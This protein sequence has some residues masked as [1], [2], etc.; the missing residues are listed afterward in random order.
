MDG[1]LMLDKVLFVYKDIESGEIYVVIDS[2][3]LYITYLLDFKNNLA[4]WIGASNDDV[5]RNGKLVK[6]GEE[7]LGAG[8]VKKVM[9]TANELNEVLSKEYNF[10]A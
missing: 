9:L 4:I 2:D 5:I 3:G 8:D 6:E 10:Y 1:K 7:F